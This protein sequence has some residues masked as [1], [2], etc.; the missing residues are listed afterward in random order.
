MN[1]TSSSLAK[2]LLAQTDLINSTN[3]FMP[4]HE[5]EALAESLFNLGLNSAMPAVEIGSYQG[6]STIFLGL[7]AKM[8]DRALIALD[9]HRGSEENQAGWQ[10]HD[11]SLVEQVS[12]RMDTL[13]LFRRTIDLA[14]LEK[15]VV[16]VVAE[17]SAFARLY[18]G[19]I[20][21]LFIDGGHA[22]D[23]AHSDYD[24][25]APK[26]AEGGV[27]AIHDVFMNIS[28]GGRAPYELYLRALSDNFVE[29]RSEGSLRIMQ[30]AP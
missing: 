3:G 1:K 23:I 13:Y 19:E 5:G 20:A 18:P 25:W 4:F 26:L 11:S 24:N 17:S 28:E 22:R 9:H 29:L 14:D 21:Y 30:K 15:T 8:T 27:M 7:A 6:L 16:I 12:N 10:F 2:A